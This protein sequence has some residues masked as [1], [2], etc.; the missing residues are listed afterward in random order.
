[1]VN[2]QT[3][4]H[5]NRPRADV[6]GF[7]ADPDNAPRWYVNIHSSQRLDGGPLGTGSKV[8]FTAKF[9][10]RELNY[11]YEFVEYV[12]GEK[13]VMRT[14][15]GPFPMQTTY[16]WTDDGGGTRMTLGNSGSPS[17]F[18]R[19]AGLVMEPMMRRENRKDL[20]RLK[21]ILEGRQ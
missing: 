15:Q 3:D 7:A 10:G 13:L 2:V 5:I 14:D 6:A 8:A 20:E 16:T 21:A 17:G 18:S 9:L 12:P 1:M 4:I 11:T 19:L